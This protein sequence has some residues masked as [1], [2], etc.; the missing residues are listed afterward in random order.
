M[1]TI[2]QINTSLNVG[3]TG[4]IA[5]QIGEK[6]IVEGWKSYI[7]Y[8]RYFKTSKS[9]AISIGG[10]ISIYLHY[11]ISR[12]FDAHGLGSLWSTY[13]FI[14]KIKKINPDIVHLQNLHGYY[15]NYPLLF[16]YLSKTN[17]PVVWTMHDCWHFTGHLLSFP[18]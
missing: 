2:L 3:A 11:T 7:A 17:I 14:K 16:R 5:E 15:I 6:I 13:F 4:R 1:A 10:K 18:A 9:N 8:G 12:L